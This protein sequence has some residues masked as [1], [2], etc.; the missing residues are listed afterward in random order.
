MPVT[1]YDMVRAINRRVPKTDGCK[2]GL[3]IEVEGE[4]LPHH[5]DGWNAV[6][7]GSLRGESIEYVFNAPMTLNASKLALKRLEIA[8]AGNNAKVLDTGYAGIHVHVNV[9]DFTKQQLFNYCMA[10]YIVDNL[11]VHWAGPDRVGNLFC[12]SITDAPWPL[13]FLRQALENETL[14]V[15][16]N[17]D[18]RYASLNLKALATY[19]SVEFRALRSTVDRKVI[20]QW[21]DMLLELRKWAEQ[22]DSSLQVLLEDYSLHGARATVKKLL[23]THHKMFDGIPEY[24]ALVRKSIRTIQDTIYTIRNDGEGK[25]VK[26]AI[27]EA[28]AEIAR[29]GVRGAPPRNPFDVFMEARAVPPPQPVPVRGF[30][31][32]QI[33]WDDEE[34]DDEDD[35]EVADVWEDEPDEDF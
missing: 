31:P 8:L 6:P 5:V 14:N 22:P 9:Q 12:L 1:V 27:D 2:I 11:A 23:P 26:V 21:V 3:E 10:Y 4:N 19:G 17:D 28:M 13:K 20:G 30:E 25:P 7:D 29:G 18:I 32:Q 34:P 33:V 15:L 24:D 35:E 16:N